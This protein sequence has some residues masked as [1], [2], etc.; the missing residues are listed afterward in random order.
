M[1]HGPHLEDAEVLDLTPEDERNRNMCTAM[2]QYMAR[3]LATRPGLFVRSNKFLSWTGGDAPVHDPD[4]P[5]CRSCGQVTHK[6]RVLCEACR[7]NPM[8]V[9]GAPLI[10]TMYRSSNPIYAM[11]DEKRRII[12]FLKYEQKLVDDSLT[13]AET[14]AS[15]AYSVW[16]LRCQGGQGNVY[17]SRELVYG[18]GS[19][20]RESKCG[21]NREV[22]YGG[23][24]VKLHE[25]VKKLAVDWLFELD[26]HVRDHFD[27]PLGPAYT[28]DASFMTCVDNFAT[29]ITNRV[30]LFENPG[31]SDPS[32]ILSSRGCE[33]LA[34]L[35]HLRCEFYAQNAIVSDIEGMRALVRLARHGEPPDDPKPLLGVLEKPPPELLSLVPSV[36]VD[37]GFAELR[38]AL[39]NGNDSK[40]LAGWRASVQPE[41]LCMLL[42]RAI[43]VAQAWKPPVTG[44]LK[45]VHFDSKSV[46]KHCL[47]RMPWIDGQVGS[48]WS[49]VPKKLHAHRRVGLDP[50]GE[51][52]VLMCSALM[53]I[54]AH[55]Q[56]EFFMPGIVRCDIVS[57][58]A[59]KHLNLSSYAKAHLREQLR[60][61]TAG[62]EWDTSRHELLNW[63]GSHM[64]DDVR[65]AARLLS[66]YSLK[67]LMDRFL[68]PTGPPMLLGPATECMTVKPREGYETW[69]SASLEFLMPILKEYRE[70][71][72]CADTVATHPDGEVLRMLPQVRAWK[73]DDGALTI[74]AGEARAIPPVKALLQRMEKE[75]WVKRKRP[76]TKVLWVLEPGELIRVLC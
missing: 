42:D 50:T 7:R 43:A 35:Q 1:M 23:L 37:M 48:S 38:I 11:N 66:G 29:L 69:C 34:R 28:G 15:F 54:D 5:H 67:E 65:S 62:L 32:Q 17:F 70:S 33:H 75:G 22:K 46:A 68:A 51:R 64:E 55:D 16:K 45:T 47:P 61:Y 40:K 74:T 26:A 6:R 13:L 24:G 76:G 44:F 4:R 58:V 21:L 10:E 25:V 30:T 39:G 73:P 63:N 57:R 3:I 60:P 14:L 59:Q 9:Y 27:I 8:V 71:I 36:S 41:S 53:Q 52:I 19:Y 31:S 72:G 2:A 18:G 49:F 12:V 56:P 20:A